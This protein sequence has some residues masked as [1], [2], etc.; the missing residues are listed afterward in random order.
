MRVRDPLAG[1]ASGRLDAVETGHP[2]IHEHDVRVEPVDHVQALEAVGGLVDHLRVVV[3]L[4]DGP[5]P[6]A[7]NAPGR[8]L[9]ILIYRVLTIALGAPAEFPE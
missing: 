2:D 7:D 9:K 8:R 4:E 3:Q 1:E 6:G 5:Q